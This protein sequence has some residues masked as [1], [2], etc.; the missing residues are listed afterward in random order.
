[1]EFGQCDMIFFFHATSTSA[2]HFLARLANKN[3]TTQQLQKNVWSCSNIESNAD[4]M[5]GLF[6]FRACLAERKIERKLAC[7]S[8]LKLSQE[9]MLLHACQFSDC[10][11]PKIGTCQFFKLF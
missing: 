2:L 9:S 4:Q 6:Y 3:N 11:L 7:V 5:S 1:M 10:F 8:I